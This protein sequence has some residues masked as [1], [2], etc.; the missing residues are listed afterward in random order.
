M[1]RDRGRTLGGIRHPRQIPD[2]IQ[3]SSSPPSKI[4]SSVPNVP[5]GFG[6]S[7]RSPGRDQDHDDKRGSG[8]NS[9]PGP[10]FLQPPVPS[11]KV[12]RWLETRHRP[13]AP[14]RVRSSD[15]IQD[16]NTRLGSS[17][18]Q[19][20]RLPRLDRPQ[21]RLIPD[22]RSSLLQK[23]P[24]FCVRRYGLPVQGPMFRVVN[25][26]RSVHEGFRS[27]LSLGPL[28][29]S[30]PATVPGRL[31]DPVLLR[32]QDQAT[33]ETTPHTLLLPQH[34]HKRGEVRPLLV[35]VRRIPRHDH[36]H[37]IS[38]SFPHRDS[39]SEIPLL[40]KEILI[41]TKPPVTAVAGVVGTHVIDGKTDTPRKTQD[42]FTPV[43]SEVQLVHQERSPTPSDTPVPPDGQEHLLVDGEGP[44]P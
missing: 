18:D 12:F 8:N 21:R 35:Q 23:A 11:R 26:S 14:E 3:G 10:R 4:P 1:D 19:K 43:A 39:Y 33:H 42:A 22:S 28:P 16:G 7:S 36:R 41:P 24:P 5:A 31:A 2:T 17:C 44:P 13:L 20:R 29:R 25:R 32:G 37:S 30:L 38:L 9:R 40:G 34:S 27:G 15:T 6:A